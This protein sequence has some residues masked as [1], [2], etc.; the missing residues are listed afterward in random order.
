MGLW[1]GC[2]TV[3]SG[4]RVRLMTNH[5]PAWFKF[6]VLRSV[7]IAPMGFAC[8]LLGCSGSSDNSGIGGP[9]GNF[10]TTGG[11]GNVGA[12]GYEMCCGVQSGGATTVGQVGG[13]S[14]GTG[15]S[16][17]SVLTT[18]GR[19]GGSPCGPSVCGAGQFCCNSTCGICGPAGGPCPTIACSG[20][21]GSSG[22]GQSCTQ[23]SECGAGLMCCYPCGTAGCTNQCMQ[24]T[25]NG[26]CPMFP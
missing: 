22:L 19:G 12:G 24:A 10:S 3:G 7:K 21:G 6:S 4:R 13:S 26:Q 20:T 23:S 11:L 16:S 18:G 8:L 2:G 17:A 14:S 25:P 15:G 5:S 9:G 1:H